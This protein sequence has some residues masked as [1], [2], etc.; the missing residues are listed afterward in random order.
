MDEIVFVMKNKGSGVSKTTV[1]FAINGRR[2]KK[3]SERRRI[4]N[5][6]KNNLKN[7]LKNI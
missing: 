4:K 2:T 7:N 5:K 3:S 6:R 1:F